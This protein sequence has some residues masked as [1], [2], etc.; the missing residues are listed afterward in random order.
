MPKGGFCL[1]QYRFGVCFPG[2]FPFQNKQVESCEGHLV[3]GKR[4]GA[5][6]KGGIELRAGPV[7]GRHEVIA[8]YIEAAAADINQRLLV[9]FDILL[10]LAGLRFDRFVNDQTFDDRPAEAGRFD[11]VFPFQDLVDL[12]HFTH[13]NMMKGGDDAGSARLPDVGKG[14]RIIGAIPA[15]GLFEMIH[16]VY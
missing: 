3:E 11:F 6:V 1:G 10:K 15:P 4:G 16:F 7:E 9:F 2:I 8:E 14:D 12:P 5:V 13:G